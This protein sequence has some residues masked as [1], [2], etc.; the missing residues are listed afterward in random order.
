MVMAIIK[1]A[2]PCYYQNQNLIDDAIT[3]WSVI[4][5][6]DDRNTV[7]QSVYKFI[8]EDTKGFPPVIGQIVRAKKTE[9]KNPTS[10][11]FTGRVYDTKMLQERL[12]A[13]GRK[14]LLT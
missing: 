4:L 1:T 11:N 8:R 12:V 3:L 7:L 10:Q 5:K 2:Y 6:D 9:Y 13:K 14:E